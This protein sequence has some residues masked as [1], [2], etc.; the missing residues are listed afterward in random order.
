VDDPRVRNLQQD[1]PQSEKTRLRHQAPSSPTTPEDTKAKYDGVALRRAPTRLPGLPD[2]VEAAG[3]KAAS[4]AARRPGAT[5]ASVGR[6][7]EDAERD[8]AHSG[9]EAS[10]RRLKL[11]GEGYAAALSALKQEVPGV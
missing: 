3:H 4:E 8:A 11:N 1:I 2:D 7:R 5:K 6:A 9:R 10:V